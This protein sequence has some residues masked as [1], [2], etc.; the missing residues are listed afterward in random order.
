MRIKCKK[1]NIN[2]IGWFIGFLDAEGNFQVYPKKRLLKSGVLSKVNVGLGIHITL[3][4]RDLKIIQ[5]IH[6]LLQIGTIY[7]SEAK[8]EARLAINDKVGITLLCNILSNYSLLTSYQLT[9]FLVLKKFL[10]DSIKEFLTLELYNEYKAIVESTIIKNI[11]LDINLMLNLEFI[12][13]WIVGFINGEGCF[14][15]RNGKCN[16]IIKHTDKLALELI[17]TRLEFG[18]KVS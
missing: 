8:S 4:L 17:K 13:S 3:H 5:K 15:L 16:F 7:I 10:E 2:W 1:K 6:K 9:R 14:Y 11:L 12:D 18:P